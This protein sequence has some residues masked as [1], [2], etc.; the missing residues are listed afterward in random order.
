VYPAAGFAFEVKTNGGKVATFNI[1]KGH[2][3]D[4]DFE[5]VGPCE[6][7]MPKILLGLDAEALT[8]KIWH[9]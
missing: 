7:T 4:V 2:D 1:E 8:Q 3:E 9:S 6:E 5:F